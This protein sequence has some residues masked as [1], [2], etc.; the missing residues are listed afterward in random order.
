[1]PDENRQDSLENLEGFDPNAPAT[2]RSIALLWAHT[3]Q[4]IRRTPAPLSEPAPREQAL[5][6]QDIGYFNLN[7]ADPT[8]VGMVTDTIGAKINIYL[9]HLSQILIML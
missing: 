1:M 4:D 6:A 5:R 2:M 9:V 7:V 8:G 3:L